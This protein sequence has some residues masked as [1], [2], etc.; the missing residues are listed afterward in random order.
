MTSSKMKRLVAAAGLAALVPLPVA[1]QSRPTPSQTPALPRTTEGRPNLTGFWQAMNTASWNIEP[2]QASADGPAGL[3]VIDGEELPYRP[4]ALAKKKQNVA[5]RSDA[6]PVSRCFAP[7]VPR[8]MYMPYPFQISQSRTM[9]AM[10]FEFTHEMRNVYMDTPHPPGPIDWWMGDSRGRWEGDT[11]VVDAVH[12]ND[13]TLFDRAGNYHSDALHVVE[14]YT[15]TDRDHIAYTATIED[16]KVFT[17]PWKMNMI[18][19]RHVEPNFQLLEYEC[20]TF[21]DEAAG[22]LSQPKRPRQ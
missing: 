20:S 7:G 8:I 14:R 21:E 3:G 15:M 16:A 10:L 19:Y 12:F 6:D 13:E 9:V 22:N 11:L 1:G 18:F 17:R 5:N 2:H 4:E